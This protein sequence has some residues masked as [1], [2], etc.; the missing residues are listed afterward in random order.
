LTTSAPTTNNHEGGGS[1]HTDL[2]EFDGI[3][4]G[5]FPGQEILGRPT[6]RAGGLAEDSWLRLSKGPDV[7]SGGMAIL[8]TGFLLMMT[9]AFAIAADGPLAEVKNLRKNDMLGDRA[10]LRRP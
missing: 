4:L 2:V 1:K 7:K 3:V 6:V 5:A 9:C 10:T 8:P